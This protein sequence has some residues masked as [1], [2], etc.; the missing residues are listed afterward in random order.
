MRS[1]LVTGAT[2]Y[3]G[4]RLVPEL[5][6]RGYRV[7][8]LVRDAARLRE[9]PWSQGVDTVEGDVLQPE[10]VRRS[11]RGIETAYYLVHSL[12]GGEGF[13]EQD[14]KAAHIFSSECARSGVKRI[15]YLGG[16]R[17]RDEEISEHL[18]SRIETGNELRRAGVPVTEFRA[19]MIIG[20]GSYSFELVRYLTERIPVLICP[21]WVQTPT[22][23]IA[24]RDVIFYLAETLSMPDSAGQTLDIGGPDVLAYGDLMRTYAKIRGLTRHIVRVPVLTPR[25]SSHWI[26][27]VTPLPAHTARPLIDGLKNELVCED[28]RAQELF[29]H[30][31]IGVEKAMRLALD[32]Y[33]AANVETTWYGAYS[34]SVGSPPRSVLKDVTGMIM[35]T[36][37]RD[38]QARAADAFDVVRRL[39]GN[40]GWLYATF[41]WKIR[42]ALDQFLGGVGYRR[43]R[44]HPS[45]LNVGEA[46]DFWR[47]EEYDANRRLR[48]R[49]E[50]KVP[51]RAW[52]QFDTLPK[53]EHS[54][55]VRQTAFFEPRGLAG[56]LYWYALY[57]IHVVIF[58]GM[59]RQI[60]RMAENAPADRP[61]ETVDP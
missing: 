4:G 18:K 52:L 6:E 39:G 42:G 51:G 53:D 19:G 44:R 31:P 36:R 7:R 46:V 61:L 2:G 3:V 38:I 22:Q 32:R 57:P 60:C 54:A 21:R 16:I 34:S 17:P 40:R 47:V 29:Q 58:S 50:M 9:R 11:L 49:A 8:C 12:G 30:E 55:R 26:G 13:A 5:I 1:V 43:G 41:L 23:P 37:E 56:L 33:T 27:L 59:L 15:I 28:R 10:S 20:S 35:D 45:E 25:L 24:I 14:R 48:L